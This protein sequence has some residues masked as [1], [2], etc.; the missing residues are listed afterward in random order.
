MDTLFPFTVRA[1]D[2]PPIPGL[3]YVPDYVTEAEERSL[4]RAI[5]RQPWDTQWRR[6]RQPYGA[7]YGKGPPAPPI[8]DW[9]RRLAVRLSSDGITARPFDQMLV[10]EYLPGQG[11]A[12][13]RD[14]AA[15]DRTVVSV[16]L[17]SACVMEFRHRPTGRRERLLLD[18]R[19]VLV[20]SDEARYEWEHGIPARK[21]DRWDG[22]SLA[23]AR[24]LSITLRRAIS[25]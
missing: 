9:G 6:R 10:N 19:S 7:T 17:L 13:H 22:A 25:A 21:T 5:D 23:R 2:I 16:S 3:A 24:R 20:L 4:V 12:L 11:I 1:D 8:P 18:P 15:F 14:Y